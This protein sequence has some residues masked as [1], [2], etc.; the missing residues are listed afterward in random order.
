M[1]NILKK[2]ISEFSISQSAV[3]KT[4]DLFKNGSTVPF[5]ARYR[6]EITEGMNDI[7]LRDF[8]DRWQ[9]LEDFE[10]RQAFILNNLSEQK[11]L[12][13]ELHKAILESETK[14]QLEELYS[15]YKSSKVSKAD[16]ARQKG[17]AP[18]AELSWQQWD[19]FHPKNVQLW[20]SNNQLK[21]STEDA[22]SGVMDILC[23]S[24]SLH[25]PLIAEIRKNLLDQGVIKSRVIRGK[26]EVGEKF[27]DYFDFSESIKRMSPHRMMALLRGK[28]ENILRISISFDTEEN[29]F[30]FFL[31]KDLAIIQ[32]Y[33]S[34]QTITKLSAFKKEVL[35]KAWLEKILPKLESDILSELK[36]NAESKAIE[37]FANNLSDLLMAPPAGQKAILGVDPGFRNG[38]KI[39]AVTNKGLCSDHAVIYPHPPQNKID[40]ANKTLLQLIKNNNIELIAIGNGTASRETDL[41]IKKLIKE[42]NLSCQSVIISEAGASVYSASAIASEEFPDLDVTIRGAISIAR[43]LQD[44]LAELVKIEPQAIGVGQY[45]HDLKNSALI[46]ALKA[47]VE[48]CVNRVGVNLNLASSSLLSFVSGLTPRL[49]ENIVHHRNKEGAFRSRYDLKKVSGIGDKC[50]EQCAGFLRLPSSTYALDAS[51]VHP[52]SYAL[53]ENMAKSLRTSVDKLIENT[54]LITEVKQQRALFPE[55]DDYTF[56]DVLTE[57]EKPGHDPRPK[58]TYA[59]FRQDIHS[60]EDLKPEMVLEGTVTNVAAFG[61]FVDIGVHQDG[62]IHISQLSD[63]FVKDPRELVRVGQVVKV[64][65]LEVDVKRK[66]ISLKA[67]GL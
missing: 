46:H 63:R 37:V 1:S 9:Y 33:E 23:E 54:P 10:H 59:T 51:G 47:V 42:N 48:D 8:Y 52:E 39:A 35:E 22:Y 12:S 32:L 2:L 27:Q 24:L 58:F 64:S 60:M 3:E 19:T 14:S 15:P 38:V 41:L 29:I 36:N 11:K 7:Q 18:L 50:F 56:S 31:L 5:V 6:K 43:R 26:K 17:L 4:I 30:P 45:Q 67:F 55:I 49:A 66:R 34:N 53:V 21:I 20:C 13:S 62:L 65:V 25:I 40:Q 28:K 44:P 16:I 61:A 57:L